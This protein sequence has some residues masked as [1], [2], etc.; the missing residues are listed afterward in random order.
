MSPLGLRADELK[1]AICVRRG[2]NIDGSERDARNNLDDERDESGTSEYVRPACVWRHQVARRGLPNLGSPAP[3]IKPSP[4]LSES[5][6]RLDQYL[7]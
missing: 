7:A 2:G 3:V 1:A 5:G 6:H 4:D